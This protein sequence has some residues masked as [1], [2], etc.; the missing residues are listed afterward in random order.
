MVAHVVV[1]T[2]WEIGRRLHAV[3]RI[4]QEIIKLAIAIR[5]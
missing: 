3:D 4:S 2:N 1:P 5:A